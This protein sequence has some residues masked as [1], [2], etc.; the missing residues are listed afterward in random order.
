MEKTRFIDFGDDEQRAAAE[1]SP[2]ISRVREFCHTWERA[3][4]TVCLYPPTNPLPD[5]FRS[6][7]FDALERLLDDVGAI[8]FA[9]TDTALTYEGTEVHGHLDSEENL[10]FLMFRDGINKLTFETGVGRDESTRFLNAVAD[11]YS[12]PNAQVDLVNRLWQEAL[13]HIK[14]HTLDRVVEGAYIELADDDLLHDRHREFLGDADSHEDGDHEYEQPPREPYAGVQSDRYQHVMDVFGDVSRLS[15]VEQ[16][17]VQ[18]QAEIEPPEAAELMGLEIIFDILLMADHPRIVEDTIAVTEKQFS[19]SVKSNRW[20]MVRYILEQ[21]NET[22][23]RT[24]ASASKQIQSARLRAAD[25]R[26]FDALSQYLNDNPQC[27]LSE[28]RGVLQGFGSSALTH[29]T[30]MLGVLEH[31]SARLMVC[32]YLS[33][34][35]GDAIDLIGGFVYDKRWFVVR[36][37]AMVLGEIGSHRALTFLKRSAKHADSRV[38]LETLKSL[39][40]IDAPESHKTM[41]EYLND[42]DESLRRRAV[43][44]LGETRSQ[45]V[46]DALERRINGTTPTSQNPEALRELYIAYARTG[47]DQAV[48]LLTEL[49]RKSPFFSRKRWLPI[50]LSAIY[51]LSQ[52]PEWEARAQLAEL[53]ASR[54]R[55]IARAAHDAVERWSH[56]QN[57]KHPVHTDTDEDVSDA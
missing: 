41:L 36:N 47:G 56:G 57:A 10:A 2:I 15:S 23:P 39:Q 28:V 16:A 46:A 29:T 51:A 14:Y 44:A 24:P 12:S 25:N 5:E 33:E 38:R 32:D 53:T 45:I 1:Q 49:A 8:S 54:T 18:S 34:Q 48:R 43:R 27:D 11:V 19:E 9:V 20:G 50:R 13:P 40:N 35:G 3:V 55:E 7:F 37:V 17:E 26:Y 52:S 22:A 6:K 4:K 21:W 31:R 42:N 30:A